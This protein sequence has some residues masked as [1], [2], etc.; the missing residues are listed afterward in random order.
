MSL[1]IGLTGGIA[2]G[3]STVSNMLKEMSITVIDADIEA[4]LAVMKGESAYKQ[5]I[6]EFGDG[7]LLENG[8]IDRQ[9]LGAII[10]HQADK[11]KRLNEITHPEVR[12]RMLEQVETAKRNNEEVVVLDIPLLFESK[13]TAMVEKTLL[14]YVDSDIQ[15]QRLVERNNLTI[16]DAQ[17]RINSQMPLSEKIRLADAV[18]NNNGTLEDTKQQLLM[19]LEKWGLKQK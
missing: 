11:R 16:A 9:K 6:A 5:I 15:L 3:K 13:L 8:E 7:I 14:V 12:R 4:R 10:F 2:S 19:I 17:A 1:V 18:I